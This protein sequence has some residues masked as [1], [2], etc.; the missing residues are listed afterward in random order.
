MLRRNFRPKI[1]HINLSRQD[2]KI[3]VFCFALLAT[4]LRYEETRRMSKN[5][6][7]YI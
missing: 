2:K 3:F 6:G 7:A 4:R 5:E 1:E